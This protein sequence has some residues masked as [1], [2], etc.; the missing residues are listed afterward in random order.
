MRIWMTGF[1]FLCSILVQGCTMPP[2]GAPGTAGKVTPTPDYGSK[3]YG[4]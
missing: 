3:A 2:S 4:Y 1:A